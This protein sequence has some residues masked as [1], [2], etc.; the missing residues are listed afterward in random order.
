PGA[1]VAKLA[2]AVASCQYYEHGYYAAYRAMANDALDLVVH[3]GDYIYEQRGIERVRAHDASE[4]HTL[5]DYRHRY[6]IYKLDADL[7]AAHAACAWMVVHDD[8]EVTNDYANDEGD[9]DTG[10][11]FLARRAAAYQA[12]YEHMP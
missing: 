1:A 3:V 5:D 2:L 10:E 7:Q 4:A 8:H 12:Y 6:S 9:G 11:L